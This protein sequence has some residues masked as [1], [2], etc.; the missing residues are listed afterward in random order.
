MVLAS[1]GNPYA[2]EL[3]RHPTC[4]LLVNPSRSDCSRNP[5]EKRVSFQDFSLL[6]PNL[7]KRNRSKD[8]KYVLASREKAF[9]ETLPDNSLLLK[10]EEFESSQN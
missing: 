3:V 5:F 4:I 2:E 10:L 9:R 7:L 8:F 1:P 6:E